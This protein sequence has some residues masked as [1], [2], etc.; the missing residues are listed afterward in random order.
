MLMMISGD[1]S[2]ASSEG[3]EVTDVKTKRLFVTGNVPYMLSGTFV[4]NPFIY[5]LFLS[6]IGCFCQAEL[7][8]PFDS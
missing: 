8:A 6:N 4:V 3:T 2:L 1:D 5:V 7:Y